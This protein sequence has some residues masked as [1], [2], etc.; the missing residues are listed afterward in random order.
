VNLRFVP[1]AVCPPVCLRSRATLRGVLT[2]I[3]ASSLCQYFC[4]GVCP[5]LIVRHF[6]MKAPCSSRQW[7]VG[8][9]A[10]GTDFET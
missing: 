3:M 5:A 2:W 9:R 4:T 10:A 6:S 1:A 7:A 8:K